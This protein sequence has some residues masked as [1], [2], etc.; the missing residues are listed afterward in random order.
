MAVKPTGDTLYWMSDVVKS[1]DSLS[2]A[3][4]LWDR[5]K[6]L[7]MPVVASSLAD[8]YINWHTPGTYNLSGGDA[9]AFDRANGWVFNGSSDYLPTG[10]TPSSDSTFVGLNSITLASWQLTNV[11]AA[12][13]TIGSESASGNR[14][15]K[16]YPRFNDVINARLTSTNCTLGDPGSTIG[17][18]LATRTGHASNS[19]YFNPTGSAVGTD[20]DESAT[21]FPAVGVV[22]GASNTDA[23]ASFYFNGIISI[24]LVMDKVTD[25]ESTAI[26]NI[27]KRLMGPGRLNLIP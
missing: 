9:P 3:A 7:Y 2:G 23:G 15:L 1:L 12:M 21:S 13:A 5:I 17:F 11:N 4:N 18:T 8:S 27:F 10:W 19:G 16:L 24:V 14:Y 6:L 22:I 20:T 26:F 25:A